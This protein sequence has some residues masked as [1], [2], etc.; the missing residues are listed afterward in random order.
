MITPF[1]CAGC[2]KPIMERYLMKVLDKSWH[3]QCVKCS[4]CH[5]ALNEKCFSR[6]SK[7][8]CRNDFFKWVEKKRDEPRAHTFYLLVGII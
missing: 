6:E 5:C 1:I 3:V 7:L 4:E 8:Y 2:D